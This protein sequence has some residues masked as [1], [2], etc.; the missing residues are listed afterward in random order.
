M[1]R[2]WGAVSF[3]ITSF[4]AGAILSI[5]EKA[6]IAQPYAIILF[7]YA[8]CHL[9]AGFV[10]V[11]VVDSKNRAIE[12]SIQN[13]RNFEENSRFGASP[14]FDAAC[15]SALDSNTNEKDEETNKNKQIIRSILKVFIDEPSAITFSFIVFF[16]GIASGIIDSFLFIRLKQ[17]GA[18]GLCMG[19]ARFITCATEVPMFQI[20][21]V[22]QKKFG[23]WPLIASAQLAFVVRFSY[24]SVL[25]NPWAVFPIETLHGFTFAVMW[26]VSCHYA[27]ELAPKGKYAC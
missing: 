7:L 8:L 6:H 15:E 16:S 1:Y 24:Y 2:L 20:F 9:L 25:T 21:G 26:S 11:H 13:T 23:T 17:L 19:I 3:G 10:F 4:L 12:A 14:Q 27:N 5:E 18:T 22:L